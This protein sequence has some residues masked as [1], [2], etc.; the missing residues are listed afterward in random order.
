M[1]LRGAG[2]VT[3]G[4]TVMGVGKKM[5]VTSVRVEG[6]EGFEGKG[7]RCVCV[8]CSPRGLP[9][10]RPHSRIIYPRG[11]TQGA[12]KHAIARAA[13]GAAPMGSKQGIGSQNK[14]RWVC[15]PQGAPPDSPKRGRGRRAALVAPRGWPHTPVGR[16]GRRGV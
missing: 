10:W 14:S 1:R 8:C 11:G 15:A 12:P 7:G 3:G 2:K 6:V 5:G 16:K 13:G 9:G 4:V